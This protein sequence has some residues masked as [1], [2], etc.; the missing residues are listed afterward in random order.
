MT[1]TGKRQYKSFDTKTKAEEKMRAI[2]EQGPDPAK[3]QSD[4]LALLALIKKQ[5]GDNAAE[6]IRN[7]DF[8]EKTI[9]N[10]P[11]EKRV[12]LETACEAFV[13]RQIRENRNR[14]TV[15]SDRQALR[16]FCQFA[17]GGSSL[18]ELTE[19]KINDYFD[20]MKPG[21]RRRT[22]HSRLK[23]FFNWCS[24]SGYLGVNPMEKIRPREKWNFNRE[25]LDIE[26]FRRILFVIAGLEPIKPGEAPN[27]T[28]SASF[29]FLCFGRNGWTTATGDYFL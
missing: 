2:R 10:I 4:D 29:A 11:E 8:A 28:V 1:G 24:E 6:V 9:G 27:A 17:G 25:I 13:D 19:T 23:K 7:L 18:M 22:Q 15:Y 26:V 14:R 21:G 20:T 16:Y 3:I 5:F 12:D